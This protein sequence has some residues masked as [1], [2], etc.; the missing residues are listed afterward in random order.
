MKL[1]N[2]KKS[3][4]PRKGFTLIELLVTVGIMAIVITL[5]IPAFTGLGRGA[6]IDRSLNGLKTTLSLARQWAI[7]QRD[8]VYVIF[9]EQEG[10]WPDIDSDMFHRSYAAFSNSEGDLISEW[11]ILPEG[12]IIDHGG[13]GGGGSG[14]RAI[15]FKQDGSV[16]GHT[17]TVRIDIVEGFVRPDG[18]AEKTFIRDESKVDSV[19]INGITGLSFVERDQPEGFGERARHHSYDWETD[20]VQTGTDW[21]RRPIY[22]TTTRI[23]FGL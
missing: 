9:P 7:T 8:T 14:I 22:E 20:R 19:K 1:N 10:D 3:A 4:Y 17:V 23:K 2:N 16:A 15:A 6:R 11:R 13:S 18:S 12:V 21:L 5:T